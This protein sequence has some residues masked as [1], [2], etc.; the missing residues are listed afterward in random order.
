[1][2][3]FL[4]GATGV[5]GRRLVPLLVAA[6]HDVAGT[7]R[8]PER[9]EAIT[10]AGGRPMVV[11]VYDR[12]ALNDAVS[13][14]RPDVVIHQLTD[15][16][17][18]PGQPLGEAELLRNAR[19]R[20]AGTANLAAAARAAGAT[21]LIAQSIAWLYAP[22]PEPHRESDPLL[23]LTSDAPPTLRGIY[24]LERQVATDPAF[25]GLV[26]RYGRLYG[27]GTWD[28]VPPEPPTVHVDAAARAAMLAVDHGS[29]GIYNIVDDGGPVSNAKARAELA[30]N[31]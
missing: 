19:I 16:T 6:G 2:R 29:P 21:R 11:D 25:E 10:R 9:A 14:F 28:P 27:E 26:L 12:G 15:L 3:I 13:A 22:G 17:T 30:W 31:P 24:S 8:S 20:E 7:T 23:P 18:P 5:I 1:M 4:A